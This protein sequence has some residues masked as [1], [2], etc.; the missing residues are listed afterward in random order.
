[1]DRY[2]SEAI[3]E[4]TDAIEGYHALQDT[5]S[6][7]D[8]KERHP[9]DAFAFEGHCEGKLALELCG[10]HTERKIQ[11]DWKHTP[12]WEHFDEVIGELVSDLRFTTS[13][14]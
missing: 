12:D 11:L 5:Y 14:S 8:E 9:F 3:E 13:Y 7:S 4:W 6:E 2:P 10:K 1:M